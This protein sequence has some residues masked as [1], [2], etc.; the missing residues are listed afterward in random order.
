MSIMI[1][2][3][4]RARKPALSIAAPARM[5]L[6]LGLLLLAGCGATERMVVSSIPQND[7]KVRHPIVLGEES[8]TLEILVEP[9]TGQFDRHSAAQLREYASLYRNF[10]V[11][12]SPSCRRLSR[13]DTARR[14][15]AR[16]S[17]RFR[18]AY[19]DDR[20]SLSSQTQSLSAGPGFARAGIRARIGKSTT[21]PSAKSERIDEK[22]G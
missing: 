6:P 17:L 9:A 21:P 16:R 4:S 8:R 19:A 13:S 15:S 1:G 12:P 7:Y 5:L 18:G 2:A 10:A 14:A 20:L 22:P 11:A 3:A